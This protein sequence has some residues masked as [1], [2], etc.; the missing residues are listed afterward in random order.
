MSP[1]AEDDAPFY[2][3]G[4]LNPG[5]RVLFEHC[6][7]KSR[8]LACLCHELTRLVAS[9]TVA[10]ASL[11]NRV[12]TERLRAALMEQIRAIRQLDLP[13]LVKEALCEAHFAIPSTCDAVVFS[14][15]AGLIHWVNPAFTQLCGYTLAE[16]HGLRAGSFLRG[17]ESEPEAMDSLGNALRQRTPAL[18]RIVNYHKSGKP[19]R[20]E[21]DLRPVSKGFVALERVV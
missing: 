6:L 10:E 4:L 18:R 9:L 16:V 21:I 11:T 12:P 3:L 2:V 17:P 8:T 15:E 5:E 20:V 14:D 1:L 19:Y 13:T 7:C